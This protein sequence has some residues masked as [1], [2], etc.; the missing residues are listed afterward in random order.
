M[1]WIPF[2]L[3]ITLPIFAP[4]Q[5]ALPPIGLWREALPYSSAKDVT[6]SSS[7]VYCAT[8]YSLF[9][10][11]LQTKEI[12][13]ISKISGL[14]ETSISTIQFD[15]VTEDLFIAYTNSNIDIINSSGIHNLPYIKQFNNAGDKSIYN[16]YVQNH[17]AYLSTGL[18]VILVNADKYEIKDSWFIGANGNYVKT[19]GFT[20]GNNAYYAATDEGLKTVSVSTNNAADSHNWNDLSGTNGLPAGSCKMVV[21]ISNQVY[22]LVNDTVFSFTNNS[23]NL[24]F[25]NGIAINNIN[26]SGNHLFVSQGT[27]SNTNQVIELA[28]N[29]T[30][31]NTIKQ[32]GIIAYPLKAVKSG[33]DTWIADLYGGLSHWTGNS[34]EQYKL[35]SPEDIAL[36]QI[37]SANNAVYFA[38]GSVNDS[39]NYLYNRNGLYQFGNG[40]WTNYNQF[41]YPGLDSV[42]DIITIAIDPRDQSIWEGS[43]GG[44]LI[45]IL[46]NGQFSIYKQNSPL[47]QTIGDPGSYRVSGLAFDNDQNLWISNYGSLAELHVLKNNGSWRS[48][49]IPFY[50]GAN[51]AAQIV[52]D[53]ANQ[54]WIISPPNN[55]I[56][57]FNDNQTIDNPADDQWKLITNVSGSGNLTSNNVLSIAKDK[58]GFIWVGTSNGVSV[59]QCPE[60]IFSSTG[61]EAVWPVINE[62]SF[63]DYLFKGVTVNDIAV[64]G[65]NQKWFATSNG[66]WLLSPEGDKVIY[67]FTEDNSPLLSNDVKKVGINGSTGEVYFGTSKGICSFRGT[68]TEASETNNKVLVFPNPVPPGYN[69][70]IAIRGVPENSI[71]RIT[72]LNG[73]LV[74]QTISNGGQAIW[75]GKDIRGNIVSSGVYLVMAQDETKQNKIVTKIVFIGR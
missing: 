41:H 14:S 63:A 64:D 67:H 29:G 38:A 8:P 46:T 70:S 25:A 6:I 17:I 18:G 52:I 61:C 75:N 55:G 39:W 48:F 57:V 3:I 26:V 36:G 44:G 68:A 4:A 54:K 66:A 19:N 53:D 28:S 59:F 5:N 2:F 7:K 12:N 33:T 13:R 58:N 9:T 31:L 71:V 37:T 10:V 24:F 62:G 74:Y 47:L 34:F 42:M 56:L 60:S 69:G 22:A 45:H 27:G 43:Y 65:A 15:D 50:V 1:R 30:I 49:S 73:R 16:I 35:N 11:D 40:T 51:A 32:A 21:S 20:I 72:E 23:W